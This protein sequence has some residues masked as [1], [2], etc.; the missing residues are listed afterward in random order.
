MFF[1]L[2]GLIIFITIHMLPTMPWLRQKL[3]DKLGRMPYLV[4][5]STISLISILLIIHG[6]GQAPKAPL[7]PPLPF[8][9]PMAHALMPFVFILLIAAYLNT[10][11][12]AK[13][14]HPM[15]IA[16]CLWAFVHLLAYEGNQASTLLFSCFFVYALIDIFLAKPRSSLK[17]KGKPKA[18]FDIIAIVVGL[19]LFGLVLRG[20]QTLFGVA[21]IG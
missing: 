7:W 21:V 10:H 12:R 6:F 17:P 19:T 8:A 16:T 9:R 14:K 20:H 5:F 2:L 18:L 3:I 11:I 4:F 15:L 13:L 1:L